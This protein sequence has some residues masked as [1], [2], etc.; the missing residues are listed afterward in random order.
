MV[1]AAEKVEAMTERLSGIWRMRIGCSSKCLHLVRAITK[2]FSF[3][4]ISFRKNVYTKQILQFSI[5]FL[6]LTFHLNENLKGA[7]HF[8]AAPSSPSLPLLVSTRRW[9]FYF[10]VMLQICHVGQ[11]FSGRAMRPCWHLQ[12]KFK[13]CPVYAITLHI[14]N[15]LAHLQFS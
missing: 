8:P 5:Q 3:H 9:P 14:Q 13:L 7:I 1:Q 11:R 15:S 2:P 10:I 4:F 12:P 6:L